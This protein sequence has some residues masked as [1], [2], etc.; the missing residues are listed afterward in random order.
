MHFFGGFSAALVKMHLAQKTLL[1]CQNAFR[2]CVFKKVFKKR[3]IEE[4]LFLIF[5][6]V[7]FY[8]WLKMCPKLLNEID[9]DDVN[10]NDALAETYEGW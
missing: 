5:K 10:K 9:E 7:Y 3:E 1:K 8:F 4:S 2:L 6:W